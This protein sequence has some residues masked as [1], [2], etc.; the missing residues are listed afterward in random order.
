VA[1]ARSGATTLVQDPNVV[2]VVDVGELT[3][4]VTTGAVFNRAGIPFM[5][6][7]AT[8]STLAR[9][10]WKTF[11]RTI[12]SDGVQGPIAARFFASRQRERV[13][14]VGDENPYSKGLTAR[15]RGSLGA[16]VVGTATLTGYAD[17]PKVAAQIKASH[18]D[19]VFLTGWYWGYGAML[20]KSLGVTAG[21]DVVIDDALA[22]SAFS[23][24]A[25]GPGTKAYCTVL[26]RSTAALPNSLVIAFDTKFGTAPTAWFVGEGYLGAQ[27]LLHG[28]AA[29]KSSRAEME[30][31]ADAFHGDADSASIAF[32]SDGNLS[33]ANGWIFERS[34]AGWAPFAFY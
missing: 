15:A 23:A 29:G 27:V 22:N 20:V 6:A 13:F 32:D 18:A 2:G 19:G 5:V 26:A 34:G 24:A 7:K 17:V 8:S 3:T 1:P 14:L 11:H 12:V 33:P 30:A 31:F 16:A 4:A 21:R 25:G 28:L 10:G 9:N